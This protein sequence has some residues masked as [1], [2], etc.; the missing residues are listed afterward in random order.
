MS[1]IDSTQPRNRSRRE[2]LVDA[3]EVAA[4]VGMSGPLTA[5]LASG[6]EPSGDAPRITVF[7]K[8]LQ[9]LDYQ[10]MAETAVILSVA[11]NAALARYP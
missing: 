1:A 10:G 3:V 11:W 9:W 5:R 4:V 8:Y 7:S 6:Q 2:F